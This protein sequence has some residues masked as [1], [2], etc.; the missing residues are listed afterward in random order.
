MNN[1]RQLREAAGLTQFE[2]AVKS[3][4]TPATIGHIET[5]HVASP[6]HDTAARIA[7]ALGVRPEEI[8]PPE[9]TT[10]DESPQAQVR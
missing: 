5:G 1:L 3:G 7:T 4:V 9:P 10:Q 6:R 2:L 8:W